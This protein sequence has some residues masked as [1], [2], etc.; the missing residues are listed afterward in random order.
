[1]LGYH[2]F[3]IPRVIFFRFHPVKRLSHDRCYKRTID[4]LDAGEQHPRPEHPPTDRTPSN[5]HAPAPPTWIELRAMRAGLLA[6]KV[7][8][9]LCRIVL[10]IVRPN[11]APSRRLDRTPRSPAEVES[12]TP[13]DHRG[14][15][16]PRRA[17][18]GL[19]LGFGC[20]VWA[21]ARAGARAGLGVGLAHGARTSATG[22]CIASAKPWVRVRVS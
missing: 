13:N 17:H 18:L 19:G 15:R 22:T 12:A 3:H 2:I 9:L 16:S 14:L 11:W 6:P 8:V 20:R 1:M 4:L 21:G 5:T 10:R 7:S